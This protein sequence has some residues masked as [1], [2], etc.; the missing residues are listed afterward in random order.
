MKRNGVGDAGWN[1]RFGKVFLKSITLAHA[2]HIQMIDRMREIRAKG[3]DHAIYG[4]KRLMIPLGDFLATAIPV[5]EVGKLYREKTSLQ[6]VGAAIVA[7][8]LWVI[9]LRLAMVAR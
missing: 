2:D 9:L 3:S 5:G 8:H 1:S 6:R 4:C 7:C